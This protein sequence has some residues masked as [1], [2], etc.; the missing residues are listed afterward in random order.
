MTPTPHP[1]IAQRQLT[2]LLDLV[3]GKVLIRTA[4]SPEGPW[5]ADVEV[6]STTPFKDYIYAGVAY[7]Y[8]DIGSKTLTMAY[9]NHN[10]IEVIK[11]TFY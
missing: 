7:P 4:P 9:T 8:L 1:R 6:Y 5:S 10:H 11:T 3:T 2:L